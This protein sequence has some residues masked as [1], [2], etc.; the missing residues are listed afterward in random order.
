MEAGGEQ[1]K[2]SRAP[3]PTTH[4]SPPLSPPPTLRQCGPLEQNTWHRSMAYAVTLGGFSLLLLMYLLDFSYW[5]GFIGATLRRLGISVVVIA[6]GDGVHGV[7]I[8]HDGVGRIN[9]SRGVRRGRWKGRGLAHGRGAWEPANAPATLV[10]EPCTRHLAG[11]PAGPHLCRTGETPCF[12][13]R[14]SCTEEKSSRDSANSE[15]LHVQTRTVFSPRTCAPSGCYRVAQC[16]ASGR[17]RAARPRSL[18]LPSWLS[19]R[20]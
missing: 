14:R 10:Q 15:I 8:F 6:A 5:G 11:H 19:S 4:P 17:M 20:P 16:A 3:A 9:S 1:P 2:S 7:R 13:D 12:G 18:A